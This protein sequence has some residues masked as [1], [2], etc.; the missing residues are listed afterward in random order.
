MTQTDITKKLQ[1]LLLITHKPLKYKEL[2][3]ELEVGVEQV[4][5]AIDEL[6]KQMN[7]EESGWWL[8][9]TNNAVQLATNPTLAEFIENYLEVEQSAE[10]TRPALEAL[11]IIAYCGPV[12]KFALD[13]IRGVNCALII[14]NLLI[15]GLVEEVREQGEIKYQVTMDFVRHLGLSDIRELPEYERLHRHEYLVDMMS[16]QTVE[17]SV[18]D[19]VES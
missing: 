10:L 11:T 14:R 3:E 17:S 12:A 16:E 4:Q 15:K 9:E 2:A 19:S 1:A 5:V 18:S 6:Q 8:I 13:R 7:R